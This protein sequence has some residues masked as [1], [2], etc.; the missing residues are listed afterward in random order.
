M[1]NY[2]DETKENNM[3]ENR[4]K[5]TVESF[6]EVYSIETS[7]ENNIN[8]MVIILK[9]LLYCIGYQHANIEEVLGEKEGL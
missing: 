3:D 7:G 5:I 1:Y 6:G 2:L 8:D 9:K 4:L